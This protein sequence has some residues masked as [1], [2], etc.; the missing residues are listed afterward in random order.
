MQPQIQIPST[1]CSGELGPENGVDPAM[2]KQAMDLAYGE[3]PLP[4]FDVKPIIATA[5]FLAGIMVIAFL[6][7]VGIALGYSHPK[8]EAAKE[9]DAKLKKALETF[10]CIPEDVAWPGCENICG[11]GIPKTSFAR[12]LQVLHAAD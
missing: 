2:E 1:G 7:G 8:L 12:T 9:F 10:P 5:V 6:V 4:V 11:D 3:H